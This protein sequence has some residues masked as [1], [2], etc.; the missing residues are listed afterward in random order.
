MTL[1]H[2]LIASCIAGL[3][4]ALAGCGGESE[5]KLMASAKGFV[6]QNDNKS[7]IIQ[8]KSALQQNPKSGEARL[9]LGIALRE[10]GDPAGGLLEL[11]K[12][13]ELGVPDAQ[14]LPELAR[15]M[16]LAGEFSKVAGQ[17]AGTEL[18]EP[19]A[20]ADLAVSVAQS[21]AVQGNKAQALEN[22]N[23]ALRSVP[24]FAP[25]IVLQAQL[26]ASD[27]DIDGGLFLL[28]DVLA[29]EPGNVRAGLLKGEMLWQGKRDRD[30][31]LA[32][33]RKVVA[34][35]PKS[36]AA[37]AAIVSILV[38]QQK[39]DESR[40]ELA[41]LSK[42]APNHPDTLFLEARSAFLKSDY[43]A[44]REITE[45]LLKALPDN[46]P[47]LELAGAAEFRLKSDV[48][49][50]VLLSR[51]VKL[52]PN[53]LL[54]RHLLAQIH[55]RGGQPVR[56]IEVLQPAID[57]PQAD[58]VTLALAG[59][60][61]LQSGDIVRSDAAFQ[62]AAKAAPQDARVR[63]SV[64]MAQV[65]RGNAGGAIAELESLTV[66]DSSPR[67]D[68]ALVS[69]RLRQKDLPGALKAV[70]GLRK[71]MP[72]SPL[73]DLL[74]GRVL[75]LQK[76]EAAATAAFQAALAKDAKY[77]PA[78]SSLAAMD[79]EAGRTDQAK[80]RFQALI[81]ADPRNH[82]AHLALAEIAS[83]ANAPG[84]EITRMVGEAVKAAP[85]E[86][87]PRLLLVN[88]LLRQGDAK[89][90]LVAAQDASASLPNNFEVMNVLG[91]AQLASGDG[92]QAVSTFKKLAAAQPT[93]AFH[94]MSLAEAQV[95]VK[96]SDGAKVSL[97]RALEIDPT[98]LPAHRGLV[99]IA[100]ADKRPDDAVLVAR[101]FQRKA[102]KDMGG[103]L[104]EG[105]IESSRRNWP[106]A[107]AAYRASMQRQK[108]AE[109]VMGLHAAL[110]GT[111]QRADADRLA[112]EWQRERPKDA[113][114]RY[115]LG[116]QALNRKDY[117]AAEG[118]YKA[119]LEMQP[120][121]ALAMNNLAW[122]LVQQNKPGAVKLAEDA[123][124]LMPDRAPLLDT[125][126]TA[127]AAE[128]QYPRAIETQKRA[129]ARNP[130]DPGLQLGLARI[131]IQSGDKVQAR[132]ELEA[133]A[134]LGDKFRG[135][136]EVADLLK[137]VQ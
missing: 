19:Q 50:E 16:L 29:K 130:Q 96:D 23:R 71:K 95:A 116:D 85:G 67:A 93:V 18:S 104:L 10:T 132:G 11:R 103:F 117:A 74:Q 5:E 80:Q 25:A 32:T 15:T 58:G 102:P 72:D 68:L 39:F 107:A 76:N 114:F 3:T 87:Q 33:Y 128:K 28:D 133:L 106:A 21:F 38:E 7:A 94:Q 64:A 97:K 1:K 60:A 36:V 136:S 98:L 27:N 37:R 24:G 17:Y 120:R 125:L 126:A 101:E 52:A 62:R 115:Y 2:T 77:F 48:Q 46:V 43:T 9:M 134:K 70:E 31:A 44:T 122:L 118:H 26:K 129:I 108:T 99:S 88:H 20:N 30:G 53:R 127:L 79:L 66:D 22:S 110:I 84:A 4:L 90:A 59:E 61:Y 40:T 121:N 78:V 124:T 131:Y 83:R 86:A 57:S 135:Q 34:A 49:A 56:A 91:R 137:T 119:V 65:V 8:L 14:L 75:V 42:V 111:G 92:Q 12:A 54:P 113:A 109:A 89:A 123:N 35:S 100:M 112:A 41:E 13:Q 81:Q 73:P 47:A 69:G 63:T 82:R 45:R 105:E 55:V 51:A 6:A